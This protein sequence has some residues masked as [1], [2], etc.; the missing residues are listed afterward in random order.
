MKKIRI[1]IIT[2]LLLTTTGCMGI[3]GAKYMRKAKNAVINGE[4]YA[5]LCYANVALDKGCTDKYFIEMADILQKYDDASREDDLKQA[6]YYINKIKETDIEKIEY[7]D[8]TDMLKDV[9]KLKSEIQEEIIDEEIKKLEEYMQKEFY[10][11]TS[12]QAKKLLEDEEL[13][14]SQKRKIQKISDEA[15]EKNK[16]QTYSSK[17]TS[18]PTPVHPK[19]KAYDINLTEQDAIAAARQAMSKPNATAT[20]TLN[21]NYYFVSFTEKI[22]SGGEIITDEACCKVDCTTGRVYDLIG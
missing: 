20:A 21:G 8:D 13:T 2:A 1:L 14:D 4:Y 9:N 6:K 7:F 17:Q 12:S 5:A 3:S 19:G 22:N 10:S 18:T 15:V 11:L 16:K